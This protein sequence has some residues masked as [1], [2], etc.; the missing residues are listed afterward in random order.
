VT[1]LGN[2]L[3]DLLNPRRGR[4]FLEPE[5]ALPPQEPLAATAAGLA[6]SV[7]DL[8]VEFSVEGVRTRAVD[9]VSFEVGKGEAVGLVGESG[10]GKTT[11][12]L[13]ALRLLPPGGEIIAGSVRIGDENLFA[14]GPEELRDLR[15]RRMAL[16]FQ[17]AMNA[18]NPVRTVGD[19]IEEA[20]EVHEPHTTK[21]AV[22]QRSGDLLDLVGIGRARADEYPHQFSGGMRQRAMIALALACDPEVIVADEPT[23]ALDVMIQAQVMRLLDSLRR[24]LGMGL[25]LITHDLGLV[26]E[27]CDRV[28][29]MY[30]GIVA[31]QGTVSEVYSN[32]QHPYTKLLLEAFPDLDQPDRPLISIPGTPPRLDLIPPGC[33][34]APRCP[35]AFDRCHVEQPASY[36]LGYRR[37]AA[38]FLVETKEPV[39]V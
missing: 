22:K 34:F 26:A 19:Q 6:M 18:L 8:I 2:A 3:E 11:A 27:T 35:S 33:R 5:P 32:P 9:G 15:W 38:C 17:G 39:H 4:H 21:A 13:A 36:L 24:E 25:V 16:V 1:L 31:E 28:V 30:G 10:S 23:T 29:V 37:E 7:K 12:M 20:I 14:L